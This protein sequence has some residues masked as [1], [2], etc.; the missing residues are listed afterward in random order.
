MF[1]VHRPKVSGD[2]VLALPRAVRARGGHIPRCCRRCPVPLAAQPRAVCGFSFPCAVASGFTLLEIAIVLVVIGALLAIGVASWV[3]FAEGRRLAKGQAQLLE[4]RD[5]LLRA[6]LIHERYPSDTNFLRCRNET[7][8]DPWG[9][10]FRLV[11]GL[12]NATSLPLNASFAVV[13]DPVRAQALALPHT[14]WRILLP[15]ANVTAIAFA[16]VSLGKDHLADHPSYAGLTTAAIA[17]LT[18][19]FDFSSTTKDDLVLPVQ[20]YEVMGFLRNVVGP[21]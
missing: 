1:V 7:G 21:Q 4:L 20:G 5:C 3:T 18:N 19:D 16:L 13:T 8:P 6:S 15:E 10:D 11:R 2:Y 17:N 12:D 9:G 14:G